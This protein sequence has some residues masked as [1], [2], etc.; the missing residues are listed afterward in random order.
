[1][2]SRP[3][4]FESLLEAVPDALVGMDQ[5]GVIR[6]VN[7]ETELLFGYDRDDLVG[8]HIQTLVPKALWQV[9]A[10]HREG[11]FADPRTRAMG[12]D[13]ELSGQ[14]LDGTGFP[15]NISLSQ[16][17]T[18]DVLLVITAV[19]DETQRRQIFENAQVTMAM[20][21]QSRDAIYGGTLDGIIRI[22]NRAA[23]LMYGYSREEVIGRSIHLISPPDRTGEIDTTLASLGTGEPVKHLETIRYRKDRTAFPVSLTISP[24][25]D[26]DGEVVGAFSIARD[27]SEQRRAFEATQRIA[28]IVQHSEDAIVGGS[29]DG[30]I[31]NWNPAAEKMFGY[32]GEEI[33]GQPGWLLCPPDRLDESNALLEKVGSG[34]HVR[35]FET[36]RVR[37]NGTAITVSVSV[38]PIRDDKGEVVGV[39]VI[40]RDVTRQKEAF[41]A[42]RSMIE[43]SLDSLVAMSP[44]G[45]ITDANQ[46]TVKLT[47]VSRE[48]LIGTNFSD[49]FT[50][51][52]KANR[53]YQLVLTEGSAVD[54]PLTLRH[55][56]G[57]ETLTEVL[58][59]ASAYRDINGNLL[60]VF[61]SARD[62]TELNLSLAK[63]KRERAHLRA[64]VDSLLDP[65]LLLEAVRDE[66]EQIVDFVIV[67][68]NPVACTY[69]GIERQDMVGSRLLDGYPHYLPT[70]LFARFAQ[71]V[72]TGEPLVLDD[73][74]YTHDTMQAERLYDVRGARVADGLSLT[75]RDVTDRYYAAQRLAA[76]EEEYRLLA[77]NTSDVTMRLC[78]KRKYEWVSGSVADVLGWQAPDLVGHGVDEFVHP[79]DLARFRRVVAFAAPGVVASVEFRFRCSDGTHRWVAWR[80]RVKVDEGGTPV[81]MVGGLVDIEERK[82]AEAREQ[83]RL[84]ELE[85]FHRVTVGRELQMIELKKEI[86]FLRRLL[87]PDVAEPSDQ[88]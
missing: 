28:A 40:Y 29:L 77:E 67:D 4:K 56:D 31:N 71:V 12:L 65:H 78:A 14:H 9:Y 69:N 87:P 48:K 58:Y 18:G 15:V 55:P 26:E 20:V 25:R 88:R 80:T 46:A 82:V 11:Y 24:I 41:E 27:V 1:M 52:E 57:H 17:D 50:A 85:Q 86:E 45:R 49:Y 76:S 8:K 42:A 30:I 83:E 6:F 39:S 22:W 36:I 23:E 44:E 10:D 51:P 32:S 7:H 19:R 66:T 2:F 5:A 73:L 21:E 34:Q 63:T 61:A 38:S 72:E 53:I 59:N 13:L 33:V 74:R 37:K 3:T 54:Y 47:G 62:V 84:A 68:A 35:H 81:A 43:S 16:I 60:G 70:G 79:E 75:F 64:T